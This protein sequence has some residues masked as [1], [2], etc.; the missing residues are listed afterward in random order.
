MPSLALLN[1]VLPKFI[2]FIQLILF[3]YYDESRNVPETEDSDKIFCLQYSL[4]LNGGTL[5]PLSI[6]LRLR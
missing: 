2:S 1:P 6:L 3:G 4:H 5:E